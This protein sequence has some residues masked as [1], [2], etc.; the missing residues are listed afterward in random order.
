MHAHG[1]S[2]L[3]R[4]YTALWGG[5]ILQPES[6]M[7]RNIRRCATIPEGSCLVTLRPRNVRR[8]VTIP[9]SL[10]H[11]PTHVRVH[12][13]AQRASERARRER[14]RERE[15][16]GEKGRESERECAH[17]FFKCVLL[18]TLLAPGKHTPTYPASSRRTYY[19]AVLYA[20]KVD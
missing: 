7:A 19:K 20:P 14:E 12:T 10:I 1:H 8:C 9:E 15:R 16:E 4:A 5:G 13:H 11:T 17:P 6:M 3:V 2:Q 18:I